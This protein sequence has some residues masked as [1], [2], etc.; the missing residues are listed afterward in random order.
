MWGREAV[1]LLERQQHSGHL[2]AQAAGQGWHGGADGCQVQVGFLS[3]CNGRADRRQVMSEVQCG[4]EG[5]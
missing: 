2:R 1:T 3:R 5:G 4:R